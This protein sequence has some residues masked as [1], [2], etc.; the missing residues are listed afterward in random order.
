VGYGDSIL[1]ESPSGKTMLIDAGDTGKGDNVGDYLV[2]RGISS[3][4][5]AMVTHPHPDHFGGMPYILGHFDVSQFIDNG[6]TGNGYSGAVLDDVKD[7]AIPHRTV[8]SGDTIALDSLIT[9]QVLNPQTTL[10]GDDNQDSIALK[11]VYNQDSFL[12]MADAMSTAENKIISSGKDLNVDVL[13][14]GHHGDKDGTSATF[15]SKVTPVTCIISVGSNDSGLPSNTLIERLENI[16]GT[17]I[18]RTDKKGNV[19]VTSNGLQYTVVTE[20]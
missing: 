4:D 9:I 2:S 17:S 5:I 7:L 11:V 14:V 8:R 20:E 15:L 3:L 1:I 16:I 6:Q 12:L 18:Y 10:I 13:K 19:V